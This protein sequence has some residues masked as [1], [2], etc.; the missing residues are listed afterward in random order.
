VGSG[1]T[2]KSIRLSNHAR[3]Q[4]QFRG[5]T[6]AEVVE[7][8]R[9]E[10]W[11]P[12]ALGRQECHRNFSFN[13]DWNG[14]RMRITYDAEVDALYIRFKETTVT[15]QR[16][17][18]GIAADYDADGNLAGIEILSAKKQLADPRAFQQITLENLALAGR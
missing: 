15:T 8:I 13:S 5:A 10:V 6:E 16:F 9:G 1:M 11:Q 18:E 14:K 7:T 12:A 17:A 2:E 3:E 4:L